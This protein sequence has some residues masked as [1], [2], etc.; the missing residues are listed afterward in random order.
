MNVASDTTT[1][2]GENLIGSVLVGGTPDLRSIE[3]ATGEPFD[4]AFVSIGQ[5]N[6]DRACALAP[7]SSRRRPTSSSETPGFRPRC[8]ALQR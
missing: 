5:G 7:R 4:P 1:I 8:S 6:L 3:A 2:T